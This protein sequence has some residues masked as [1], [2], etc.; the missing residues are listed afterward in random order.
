MSVTFWCPDAPQKTVPCRLCGI[1]DPP[2][3]WKDCEG[4]EEVST[5]P[6]INWPDANARAIL[7]LLAL[8]EQDWGELSPE[9]I[10]EVLRRLLLVLNSAKSREHLIT[11]SYDYH[12]MRISLVGSMPTISPGQRRVSF[13][14][15]DDH[16][17]R[18][19]S[20]LQ[21]LLSQAKSGGYKGCWG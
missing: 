15:S 18:R 2:P 3:C 5:L 6:E 12:P 20:L 13:G 7:G 16:T 17:V 9:N 21:D 11:E 19:L 4:I 8:G 10:P 14:N 1:S